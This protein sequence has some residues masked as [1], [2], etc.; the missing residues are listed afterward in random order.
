MTPNK[1]YSQTGYRFDV[2]NNLGPYKNVQVKGNLNYNP[3]FGGIHFTKIR[4]ENTNLCKY[5]CDMCPREKMTRRLGIM[6][7]QDYQLVLDRVQEYVEETELPQ[8]FPSSFFL[9]GY[10]EPLFDPK[11]AV[12][13]SMVAEQ[14]PASMPIIFSTLGVPRSESYLKNLLLEGKL[15]RIY[16]S[17]Y[18][19]QEDTYH[20]VHKGGN[21]QI[22]QK[23]L[24]Y[25][26]TLNKSLG[27]PCTIILQILIPRTQE[28]INQDPSEKKAYQELM[29]FLEPLGVE[30]YD[31]N[32]HNFGDGRDYFDPDMDTSV[33]SVVNGER[34]T[35]LNVSWDLKVLPCCFDYN[36]DIVFGDLREQSIYEIYHGEKYQKFIESHRVGNLDGYPVCKGCNVR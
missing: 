10:G 4:V 16:I 24:K 25:L 6:P 23:N 11:L 17:F 13:G 9:H 12:K 34:R 27:N 36:G 20:A 33:C 19:F 2:G 32:L 5:T 31:L 18:G 15:E 30:R 35:H 3:K 22:A 28:V 14:F 1:L 29:S 8:P 7:P 26:A 21:F